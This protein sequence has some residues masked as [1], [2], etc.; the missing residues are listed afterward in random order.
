MPYIFWTFRSTL[1]L[2]K[3]NN[4][5]FDNLKTIFFNSSILTKL[6]SLGLEVSF[7]IITITFLEILLRR[8][9]FNNLLNGT[10]IERLKKSEG[11]I[12]AD[13]FYY[14]TY[15]FISNI[16][17]ILTI[18]TFGI[19]NANNNFSNQLKDYI[20]GLP[21]SS[22][23]VFYGTV[24]SVIL[25]LIKDIVKYLSHRFQHQNQFFWDLHEFHHSPT[26]MTIFS[27]F[28]HMPLEELPFT[29]LDA[30]FSILY[31]LNLSYCIS[32]GSFIPVY[33]HFIYSAHVLFFNWCAH[34][35]LKVTYPK[36]LNII[37]MSP[38][39][40]WF[41]H[42][43][44]NEHFDSNFSSVFT[45]WDRLGGTYI[46]EER[47]H[48]I[49][50]FGVEGSEYN[51]YNPFYSMFVLPYVKISKR[52]KNCITSKSLKPITHWFDIKHA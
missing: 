17:I 16:P 51:K 46:G 48:E 31:G 15:F 26:E 12:F 44:K 4:L 33:I 39:L 10:S 2:L 22:S 19:I 29:I 47:L 37:F 52:V 40:H 13:V 42:S 25:I 14:F 36:P 3:I 41:H 8:N 21:Q 35:S 23:I 38:S 45:F 20:N 27:H 24:T 5:S 50:S 7:P 11:F 9:K 43:S 30:P 6:F 28:R 49:E 34:S 18:L 1:G 32:Q